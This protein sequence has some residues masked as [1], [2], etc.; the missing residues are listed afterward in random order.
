MISIIPFA[1]I[2][3]VGIASHAIERKIERTGHGGR[4]IYVRMA[5]Y[6]AYGVIA[7]Y[8]WRIAFRMLG[9]AFGIHVPW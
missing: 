7:L 5:T 6:V 4:V 1:Q 3:A 2:A 9:I 8:Q